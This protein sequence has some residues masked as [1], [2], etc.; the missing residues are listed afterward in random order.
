M[1]GA[2]SLVVALRWRIRNASKLRYSYYMK[3]F[4]CILPNFGAFV[5]VLFF[6]LLNDRIGGFCVYFQI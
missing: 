1:I 2:Y 6:W 4:L 3:S 5:S